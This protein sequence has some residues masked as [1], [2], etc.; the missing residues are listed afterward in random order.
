MT[1]ISRNRTRRPRQLRFFTLV[2]FAGLLVVVLGLVLL[3]PT[4]VGNV[5]WRVVPLLDMRN[6]WSTSDVTLLKEQL[7]KAQAAQADRDILYAETLDLKARLGRDASV[8]RILAGVVLRPPHTPYD[9]LMIDAGLTEGVVK[10]AVVA[11]GGTVLMG[12]VS[13]VYAH[14]ARVVLFSAPGQ[15]HEALLTVGKESI[16]VTVEGQGGGSLRVQVPAGTNAKIGDTIV[17]P[18]IMGGYTGHISY[19]AAKESESFET[20]YLQLPANPLTL[21]YVEVWKPYAQ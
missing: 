14:T 13:D 11:A 5:F 12:V 10:G 15:I 9:T 8:Q 3:Y 16:P 1:M 19:V 17:L 7:A 6:A 21:R 18:G 4:G 2:F 20:L